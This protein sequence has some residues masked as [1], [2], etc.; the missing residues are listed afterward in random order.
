MKLTGLAVLAEGL[1]M[2]IQLT[3]A[4]GRRRRR[5]KRRMLSH[6]WLFEKKN[7]D[8]MN[9]EP[10]KVVITLAAGLCD[11]KHNALFNCTLLLA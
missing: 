4:A 9:V 7:S 1:D 2:F 10:V 3:G 5:R 6:N 8:R 11:H